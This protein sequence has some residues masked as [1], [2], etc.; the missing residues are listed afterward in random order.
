MMTSQHPHRCDGCNQSREIVAVRSG[1]ILCR[2][3]AGD[4]SRW[5][6]SYVLVHRNGLTRFGHYVGATNPIEFCITHN[7]RND[8]ADKTEMVLLSYHQVPIGTPEMDI[9]TA[10]IGGQR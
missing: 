5:F 9:E 10:F 3:C 1:R 8:G 6:A 7:A 4:S 2:N